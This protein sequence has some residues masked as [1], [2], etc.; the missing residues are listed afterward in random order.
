MTIKRILVPVDFSPDSDAA[1]SSAVSLAQQLGASVHLLHV[2]ENAL[3][4]GMWS[5]EAY[6]AEVPGL[7]VDVVRE[8]K[9]QLERMIPTIAGVPF[10]LEH[11]VKVG[12]PAA[13]I[14]E[15]AKDELSD[16]IV[17]GTRGRTGLAHALMG[18]VAE[19]VIRTAPCPVLTLRA[20]RTGRG[21][22]HKRSVS[23][24]V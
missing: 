5:A 18:S 3:A 16:L 1:L 7:Q 11:E 17:M 24:R 6:T 21:K 19:H 22:S 14:V 9:E 20:D 2:V 4:A 8:A 15:C 10:G 12:P 13:T 23:A